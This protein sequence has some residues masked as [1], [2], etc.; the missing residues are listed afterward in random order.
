MKRLPP[1]SVAV[2]AACFGFILAW[3]A[4][5]VMRHGVDAFSVGWYVL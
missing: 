3:N 2:P 1:F 5:H 4:R